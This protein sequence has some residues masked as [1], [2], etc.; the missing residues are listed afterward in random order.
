[1]FSTLFAQVRNMPRA[2]PPA[3]NTWRALSN[4]SFAKTGSIGIRAIAE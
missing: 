4:P 1:M 3:R 2:S